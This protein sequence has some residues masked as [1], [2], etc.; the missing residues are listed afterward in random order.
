LKAANILISSTSAE[1]GMRNA[2]WSPSCLRHSALRTS[3]SAFRFGRSDAP[4]VWLVDL[5]G[6]RRHWRLSHKRRVQN[7]ARL[8]ASFYHSLALTR[9]D[10]LRFLR[11]YMQWGLFGKHGWKSWWREIEA[12]TQAKIARTKR[13]R[14]PL[15]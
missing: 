13:L 1:C 15:G 12:A 11:M 2:E 7:L 9:T 3:H 5:V 14:R 6:V 8:H 4:P 10:K